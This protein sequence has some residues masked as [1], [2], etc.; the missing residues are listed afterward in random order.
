MFSIRYDILPVDISSFIDDCIRIV[1]RCFVSMSPVTSSV[2]MC[3][4]LTMGCSFLTV[5]WCRSRMITIKCCFVKEIGSTC[6]KDFRG[7]LAL[8]IE[9]DTGFNVRAKRIGRHTHVF[10]TNQCGPLPSLTAK[11]SKS[12]NNRQS[13]PNGHTSPVFPMAFLHRSDHRKGTEEQDECHQRN[14]EQGVVSFEKRE[15]TEY[16]IRY[17]PTW[18][19]KP[20]CSV[21]DKETCKRKCI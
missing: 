15:S 10:F 4:F 17:R 12:T 11:E 6:C 9:I 2:C 7:F 19:T 8:C 13:H 21:C 1:T 14:K 18:H 3:S 16:I 5:G 20:K